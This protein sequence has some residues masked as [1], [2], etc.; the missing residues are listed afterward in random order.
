MSSKVKSSFLLVRSNTADND[1]KPPQTDSGVLLTGLE[2]PQVKGNTTT[3]CTSPV[4]VPERSFEP[5]TH[6]KISHDKCSDNSSV[7]THSPPPVD[8][9]RIPTP[10]M[11]G[12]HLPNNYESLYF[13]AVHENH[14]LKAGMMKLDDQN[15]RLKRHLIEL[16]KQ[17]FCVARKRKESPWTIPS[18]KRPRVSN[19]VSTEETFSSA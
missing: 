19:S 5:L 11:Q 1:D 3:T 2:F 8:E 16:Q 4:A 18:N 12:E 15:R 6:S 9:I 10:P 7:S 17:L 13:K 14:Q